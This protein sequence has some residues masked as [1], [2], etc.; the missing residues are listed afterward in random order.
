MVNSY[1]PCRW[2]FNSSDALLW[3]IRALWRCQ[4]LS[5][6][7]TTQNVLNESHAPGVCS[8][9]IVQ[10]ICIACSW[11][12]PKQKSLSKHSFSTYSAALK[13]TLFRSAKE[14]NVLCETRSNLGL[15]S[16]KYLSLSFD[17]SQILSQSHC[18][19]LW[20]KSKLRFKYFWEHQP[21]ICEK[22]YKTTRWTT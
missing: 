5:H 17:L 10:S 8:T 1:H 7:F 16:Q 21:W 22:K 18:L 3:A 15:S 13:S 4:Y 11:M 6:P 20:L 9:S 14:P 2:W 19:D 12:A